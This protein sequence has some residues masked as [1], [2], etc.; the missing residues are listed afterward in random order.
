MKQ[1]ENKERLK[2]Y[3][4]MMHYVTGLLMASDTEAMFYG[5]GAGHRLEKE[6]TNKRIV[7]AFSNRLM[8]ELRKLNPE[9]YGNKKDQ[10]EA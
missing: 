4:D 8:E 6:D 3:E 7:T 9:K 5:D 1:E 2:A 10:E